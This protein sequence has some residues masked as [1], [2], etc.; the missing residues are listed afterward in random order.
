MQHNALGGS[1]KAVAYLSKSFPK[2][3]NVYIAGAVENESFD[4]ITYV[5]LTDIPQLIKT[6][7]FHTVIVS[8]YISFYEM[9]NECS[10]YQSY[11]WAHDT[12]LLPYGCNLNETQI[13]TKWANYITGCICLTQWHKDQFIEK[14]PQLTN[15]I[16]LINNGLDLDGF[17]NTNA[18]N[19]K[20]Q[21]NKFIYSSRPERG[22]DILLGLWPQILDALPDAELVISN[23]GV[24]PE[25]ALMDTIK[26]YDSIR[27]LGKLNT[28]QL[29]A[30]MN[31]AEYW[32]YPT[33]WPETSCITALEML[34]SEVI[35]LYYPVAGL[36]F[37]IDKYGIQ[38]KS[39]NEIETLIN[40]STEAKSLLREN[41][42]IYAE[43]CSWKNRAN[44]WSDILD[45]NSELL[46][47]T[48]KK[49]VLF[50]LPF[51]YNTINLK[52]YFDSLKYFFNVL[53]TNDAN[54]ACTL[55]PDKVLFVFEVSD[56]SVYKYFSDKNIET[57]ILN[58]EP[59]NLIR[60]FSNL[61][62]YIEKYTNIKIYDYSL[63][64]IKIL[65]NN[66]Y[67]NTYHL[68]YNI[69][70]KETAFLKNI[71]E[72]TE[73]IYDFGIISPEN[74]IKLKRRADVVDYLIKNNFSVK[75][76]Q[77]WKEDRD[78]QLASCSVILNIHGSFNS[79]NNEI[80]NIFEHIRCD[81]LLAAGFNI[82]SE[83]SYCLDPNYIEKYKEHLQIINYEAFFMKN[84][85]KNLDFIKIKQPLSKKII[86]CFTFYNEINMLTY[87]LNVL[88]DVV[89]YFI[90][91][92][93]NQTHV[94]KPKPLFYNE[95]KHLFEK[96]NKK[97]IH[98]IVDLP[99]D[100]NKI[101]IANNEQWTNEKFQRNCINKGI[102][103]LKNCNQLNDDD[104]IIISDVDEIP[105][106][107]TLLQIKNNNISNEIYVIEQDFYYYNL[108]SKRNEY[109]YF[110]KLLS[111]K[112][113]KDLNTSCDNIRFLNNNGVILKKGGWHLSYFGDVAFIK[114]KL[115]NFA[116]QEF[117]YNTYTD[118]DKI[119]QKINE[120]LDLFNR[121]KND[122]SN[123]IN[124]I[125]I[126]D[127][128]YLPPLYDT[129]LTTFY[130][131]LEAK[132][133]AKLESKP[134]IFCVIHSCT[135]SATETTT[136]NYIVNVINKTGFID[137][138]DSIFIVNIGI[139]IENIYNYN[140]EANDKYVV[141]NYSD[142]A[143]FFEYPSLNLTKQISN[144][145]P[146]SYILYLHTKGITH[147]DQKL[148]N[149]NDW[150]NLMLYFLVE[151]HDEC[152][153]QLN[154]EYETVGCNYLFATPLYPM[155]YSGNF[156]WSKASY[157]NKL[158]LLDETN[159]DKAYAEFWLFIKNPKYYCIHMSPID[160]YCESYPMEKYSQN[161]IIQQIIN[162][163]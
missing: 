22:L 151:N 161:S 4:N 162:N 49:T 67:M 105:D 37:T 137:V 78:K 131:K 86:D 44:V 3:Y 27:Y 41:G 98:I 25:P 158:H 154:K 93:A 51:W 119:T 45:I 81:R 66:G 123:S 54:Y 58:S 5:R 31:T 62:K 153:N 74:P 6:T 84:T 135:L 104:Y 122:E 11:I 95:N 85:Y 140:N 156:W 118:V 160:H 14:Y 124:Q 20:K 55:N 120:G 57:S 116:H 75:V 64:N 47:E 102:D 146:D 91:V 147:S 94:G 133:E 68:E 63:S 88:N 65:N 80:S 42:R 70:D 23:Y 36:P 127:N 24:S 130:S 35:C 115:E 15:K 8:R 106:P 60:R 77:G 48:N 110:S 83:E 148:N 32:L 10:F 19:T 141:I 28:Q 132:L 128:P 71:N 89:D 17:L 18:I 76:I 109:W 111:Y 112:K 121:D 139:P 125:S 163:S 96:F 129:H 159:V 26:K 13:L 150:V 61:Q 145:N 113:Y 39:G 90:L 142:N 1:E 117:N 126:V 21:F 69:N 134:K 92:E 99:F 155:H 34:M 52:D 108:N 38:V 12:Q 16:S 107:E 53:Y 82:L 152:I 29:Y 33:H 114:N 72:N 9:F 79:F 7:A 143:S 138:V 56:E 101:N 157:I 103:I 144:D 100:N 97:I 43:S 2:S 59:L 136:L 30:E 40:L 149:V 50:F 87:R 73:K 46:F